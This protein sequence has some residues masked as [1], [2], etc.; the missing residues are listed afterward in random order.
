MLI[1]SGCAQLPPR[2]VEALKTQPIDTSQTRLARTFAPAVQ[3]HPQRSGV[4]LIENGRDAFAIRVLL[5]EAAERTLDVQYYIWR[6]DVSG[7]LMLDALS[8]AA[9]RGV[10]VRLLLDD[11]GTSGLDEKLAALDAHPLIEVRLFNPFPQRGAKYLG[12]LTD[13]SRL[14]RRMHSKSF[15]VDHQATVVGG[16][17]VADAYFGATTETLFVDLDVLA[18]GPVAQKVDE[19]FERF[20]DSASAYPIAQLRPQTT[21]PPAPAVSLAPLV[22]QM[23]NPDLTAEARAYLQAVTQSTFVASLLAQKIDLEWAPVQLVSDEPEKVVGGESQASLLH[24]RMARI[25]GKPKSEFYL[26]SPYFVPT[27]SGYDWFAG[28]RKSGVKVKVLTNALESTDV[29][30]VHAG[31]ARWRRPLLEAGVELYETRR[32]QID[33]D[34][35]KDKKPQRSQR[36]Q[37]SGIGLSSG[38]SL[39]AKTF[40]VDRQTLFVGSFNFDP[41]SVR[42]NTEIGLLIQSPHLA[43]MLAKTFDEQVAQQ[44]YAPRVAPDG[45]IEWFDEG[46]GPPGQPVVFEHEPNVGFWRSLYVRFLQLLPIDSLL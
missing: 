45:H 37:G 29:T 46:S 12:F 40:A 16:R 1:F 38:E 21:P 22:T 23:Q 15:T 2:E 24:N 27:Q 44:S 26:V 31:Y 7:G 28:L 9:E 17:N 20:W 33:T 10:R 8:R 36:S 6:D 34:L 42:L 32:A 43:G 18:I 11:L 4:H 41:R 19:A 35:E 13:F 3:A 25:V 30:A 5:A 39:H 14:N